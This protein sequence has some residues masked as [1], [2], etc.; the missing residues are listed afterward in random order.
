MVEGKFVDT[1][2]KAEEA[3]KKF[4]E[5]GID[6]LYILP[7]GYTTGMVILPCAKQVNVPIRLLATHEDATYDYKNANTAD[8]LHHSGICCIPEYAGTLLR[9]GKKFKVITGWLEDKRFWL[10]IKSDAIGAATASKF[11]TLNFAIIGSYYTNM[12][13]MPADD[14]RLMKATGKQFLRPEIE[15]FEVEYGKV[16][17]EEIEDMYRQFRWF[18]DVNE[19]VANEHMYESTEIAVV[20]DKI[21]HCYDIS[22]FGYYWWGVKELVTQLRAQSTLTGSRLASMGRPNVTE[23]DVKTAMAMKAMDLM[24][25]GGMFLEFNTIDYKENFILISHDGP[26]NFNVSEGKPKL[27]HLPVYHGKTGTGLGVD[28]NLKKG[29]VTLL[30]LTQSD[31]NCDTFKLIYRNC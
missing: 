2:E 17:E 5:E 3:A 29:T 20:Y 14:H 6:I 19:T 16:T 7:F 27:Q 4:V 18:Y 26:V 15:E 21:I 25:A 12:T 22:A 23:G 13:D 1:P 11:K 30:N 31:Y 24:G 28:F 10:E 9:I 8:F